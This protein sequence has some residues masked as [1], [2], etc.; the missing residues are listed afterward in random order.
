MVCH[1]AVPYEWVECVNGD[2]C[3]SLVHH[4]GS[5]EELNAVPQEWLSAML[6]VF[7]TDHKVFF[8]SDGKTAERVDG[9]A[10]EFVDEILVWYDEGHM[11]RIEGF[12]VV[13]RQ[14]SAKFFR[15]ANETRPMDEESLKYAMAV[16]GWGVHDVL[17]PDSDGVVQWRDGR[18]LF[19]V[20]GFVDCP[21][22]DVWCA[23][24]DA[25]S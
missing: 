2:A 24:T 18:I 13:H 16:L 3:R 22:C 4:E 12:G 8:S 23:D 14:E 11:T 17:V 19:R 5:V 9:P 25:F 7:F 20:L 6:G 15:F 21:G 1:V 10:A